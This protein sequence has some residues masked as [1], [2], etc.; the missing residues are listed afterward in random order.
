MTN[1]PKPPRGPSSSQLCRSEDQDSN[2]RACGGQP[3]PKPQH[4]ISVCSSTCKWTWTHMQWC[5]SCVEAACVVPTLREVSGVSSWLAGHQCY[6]ANLV[7]VL[8]S[9]GLCE[10]TVSSQG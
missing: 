2:T 5:R 8:G 10:W 6:C 3:R 7:Q 9:L 1:G 4:Q